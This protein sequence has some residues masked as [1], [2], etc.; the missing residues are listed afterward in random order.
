MKSFRTLLI[1]AIR[2]V[3]LVWGIALAC[4]TYFSNKPADQRLGWYIAAAALILFH[5]VVRVLQ[6]RVQAR[7][8]AS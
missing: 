1:A 8:A 4:L 7:L 6:T 5:A 3:L 2:H